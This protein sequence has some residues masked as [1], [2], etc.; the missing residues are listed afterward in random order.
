LIRPLSLADVPALYVMSLEPALG[1][2]IPDQVYRDLEHTEEVARLLI[3]LATHRDPRTKPFVLGIENDGV[4]IGH[5]G[6][7]KARGSVEIGYAITESLHGQGFAT[8]AVSAMSSWALTELRLPEVLGIVA[9]A[10]VSSCRVLEKSGFVYTGDQPA[11]IAVYRRI[12]A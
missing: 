10:N 11:G 9:T 12:A 5:V 2:W 4:L 3:E 6:L 1:R 8:E 7:S